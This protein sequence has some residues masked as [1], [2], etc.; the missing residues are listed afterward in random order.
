MPGDEEGCVAIDGWSAANSAHGQY[1]SE[2]ETNGDDA[3][4]EKLIYLL[5]LLPCPFPILTPTAGSRVGIR[6]VCCPI[7]R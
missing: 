1:R 7:I 3:G 5:G 4:Y 2:R 6:Y